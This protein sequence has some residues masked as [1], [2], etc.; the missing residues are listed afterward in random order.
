MNEVTPAVQ[1]LAQR[2]IAQETRFEQGSDT[3]ISPALRAVE[4]LRTPLAKVSGATG[5]RSLLMRALSLASA[6]TPWL[7]ALRIEPDGS[8]QWAIGT[9]FSE[10]AD[11]AAQ[12]GAALL[13]EVIALLIALIGESLTLQLLRT[14]WPDATLKPISTEEKVSLR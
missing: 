13:G 3:G 6:H 11:D 10:T 2:L 8:V 9:P 4:K 1:N 12:G 7:T 5:F 14:E